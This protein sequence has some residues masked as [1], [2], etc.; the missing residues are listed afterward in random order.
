MFLST[1][2]GLAL[3]FFGVTHFFLRSILSVATSFLLFHFSNDFDLFG[4]RFEVDPNYICCVHQKKIGTI[5][6]QRKWVLKRLLL[7]MNTGNG[8]KWIEK[9]YICT[10]IR[11]RDIFF[12]YFWQKSHSVAQ[13]KSFKVSI[14]VTHSHFTF[15]Y[16]IWFVLSKSSFSIS[17]VH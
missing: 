5:Y 13:S 16:F 6:L 10:W 8:Y 12:R 4:V 7:K 15:E 9:Y 3:F 14:L 1:Y 11:E 17:F 2:F